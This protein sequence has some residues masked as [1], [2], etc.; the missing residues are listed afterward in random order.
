MKVSLPGDATLRSVIEGLPNAEEFVRSV[1]HNMTG[2]YRDCQVRL[3]RDVNPKWPDYLVEMLFF[4]NDEIAGVQ[5]TAVFKGRSH[6][7]ELA[8]AV[9]T[10]RP[11]SSTSMRFEEVQALRGELRAMLR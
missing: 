6:K 3:A 4:E 9:N 10:N 7:G 2:Y 1:L 11:W 5:V 8:D